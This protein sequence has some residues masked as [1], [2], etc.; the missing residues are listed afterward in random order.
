[1]RGA[2]IIANRARVLPHWQNFTAR[3]VKTLRLPRRTCQ[4]FTRQYLPAI[5]VIGFK[6]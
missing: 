5:D 4:P 1:M 6:I 2:Q 3:L